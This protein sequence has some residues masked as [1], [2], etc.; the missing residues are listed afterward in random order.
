L[1]NVLLVLADDMR[2]DLLPFMPFVHTVL[3]SEGT[4][5]TN[6]RCNVPR[7]DPARAGL[8]TGQYAQGS[9]NGAYANESRG[10]PDAARDSLPV[11]LA[12][13]AHTGMVGKYL[14]GLGATKQPGW[15]TWRVLS[16]NEQEA[17]GYTVT[18]GTTPV[19]P[20]EHQLPYL[21]R[22]TSEFIRTAPEPWFCCFAPTN[23]HITTREFVNNPRPDSITRFGWLRWPFVLLDDVSTKPSWIASRPQLRPAAL[24]T[25]RNGIRQQAREVHDLDRVVAGLYADLEAAGRLEDTVIMF[26]SDGGVLY[27]EQ[28]LG[29]A[30]LPNTATK[31]HPYDPCAKVPC[32]IRGRGFDP[33]RVRSHPAVLQDLTA[34]ILALL[35]ATATVPQDG[36]DLRAPASELADRDTLYERKGDEEFPDGVGVVAGTRKL[37]RWT[38]REG[39]DRYEAYD[40]DTDPDELVSWA[41]DPARRAERDRYEA[42]LEA[43][44]A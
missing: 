44:L 31:N 13:H 19:T 35:G 9:A 37:L 14:Q 32:I 39:D 20:D 12:D 4:Q 21:A 15:D 22:E 8:L 17:F 34:T 38:G 1:T 23:P 18:D 16:E 7:C 5:L 6:M 27:A 40:L 41:N 29:N 11:W 28:R 24:S 36:V 25:L 33:G 10:I 42:R 2:A 3:R 43:L 26:A 30:A